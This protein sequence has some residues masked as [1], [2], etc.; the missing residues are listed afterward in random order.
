MI[1][2]KN[3]LLF[4]LLL[5]SM[6]LAGQEK[7]VAFKEKM[8]LLEK[9]E[10]AL[11]DTIFN[12]TNKYLLTEDQK[13][14]KTTFFLQV[15]EDKRELALS[16]ASDNR[17]DTNSIQVIETY[18][19]KYITVDNLEKELL[20]FADNVKMSKGWNKIMSEIKYVRLT[21]RGHEYIDFEFI[22]TK[23][24]TAR[25]SDFVRNNKC[26]LIDFWASWCGPC[27]A[28][29]P[30]LKNIY[31]EYRGLGL[32]IVAVS[33]DRDKEAWKKAVREEK[34]PWSN[35][36]SFNG[37]KDPYMTYYGVRGIPENVLV[38]TDGVIAGRSFFSEEKLRNEL[39]KL[40]K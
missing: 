20:Q 13:T 36:C 23:G 3:L 21:Q 28:F 5:F 1:I 18:V 17:N 40:L 30:S 27:R 14:E 38:T 37:P 8:A 7:Y 12:P 35:G 6:H 19:R 2:M 22:D 10:Q 11:I 24:D 15:R 9:R 4:L 33:C 25:L 29:I 32:E 31:E 34:M 26:V 39:D 16:Y